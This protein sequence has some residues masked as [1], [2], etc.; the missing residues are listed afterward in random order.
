MLTAVERHEAEPGDIVGGRE[1]PTGGHRVPDLAV[2]ERLG[3]AAQGALS[4]TG[5]SFESAS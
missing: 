5:F 1:Q 4:E 2:A 3:A